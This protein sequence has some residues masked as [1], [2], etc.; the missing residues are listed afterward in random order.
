MLPI[1]LATKHR[2]KKE[3]TFGIRYL[4]VIRKIDGDMSALEKELR[5]LLEPLHKEGPLLMQVDEVTRAIR[6][7]GIFLET[8]SEFLLS[9][10]F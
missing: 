8:V 10:G 3:Q 4:T 2:K 6:V 7:E 9:K 5:T 1:Y